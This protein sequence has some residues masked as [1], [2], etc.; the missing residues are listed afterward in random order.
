MNF[1]DVAIQITARIVLA[2][3]SIFM[4]ISGFPAVTTPIG[5]EQ[6]DGPIEKPIDC[7]ISYRR[8]NGSQ[9]AR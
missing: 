9:L 8:S 7:F 2:V 5:Y 1:C 6:G 4:S 3:L